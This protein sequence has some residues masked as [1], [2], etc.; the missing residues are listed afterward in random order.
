MRGPE[1]G[2][3]GRTIPIWTLAALLVGCAGN[4]D[5][6]RETVEQVRVPR[7]VTALGVA[8]AKDVSLARRISEARAIKNLARLL[9]PESLTFEFRSAAG[10]STLTLQLGP[11][12]AAPEA[13]EFIDKIK[14]S[15]VAKATASRSEAALAALEKLTPLTSEV[16]AAYPDPS[17]ALLKAENRAF[18]R[19]IAQAAGIGEDEVL[20]TG[21]LSVVALDEQVDAE[22][23][24]VKLVAAVRIAERKPLPDGVKATLFQ[25]A[26]HE[27][28]S[29]QEWPRAIA[30][31]ERLMAVDGA[32]AMRWAELGELHGYAGQHAKAAD[33][34]AQ[35]YKLQPTNL[36]HLRAEW[37]AAKRIPDEER[38][39]ELQ[40]QIRDAEDAAAK[41]AAEQAAPAPEAASAVKKAPAGKAKSKKVHQ[42]ARKKKAGKKPSQKKPGKKTKSPKAEPK[43]KKAA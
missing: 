33:A 8:S 2:A 6:S 13:T 32:T 28:H 41:K 15:W 7:T 1:P 10:D 17:V 26:V 39:V 19:V 38:V 37:N 25:E 36:D 43:E 4:T 24:K 12:E 34:Y 27:Y 29:L 35:A 20:L 16:R 23:A 18:R 3:L 22:G 11:V 14:D 31:F 42:K 21:K 40:K 30:A 5:S 9:E